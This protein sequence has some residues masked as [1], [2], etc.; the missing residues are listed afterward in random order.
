[1]GVSGL[2]DVS[3]S[4]L[5]T[6]SKLTH[7][8]VVRP[9]GKTRSLTEL[10]VTEGF[11]RNPD[12]VRGFRI[13][14]DAS[15][16]FFHAEYGKEGE[17]P[18]LRTLFF[19]CATLMK[20]PFLPLFVF[21]GPL[22]PEWKRG[23]KINRTGSKLIPGMKAIVESFG[24]EWRTAPG[25]A[26]A[27]L[28]YLNRIGV[29]DGILSD[30]VDNFLFGATTVI[31]NPSN[32]LSGN[33]ANP[34]LN[35]AGKDDKNHTKVYRIEDITSHPD[36][37]LTRGGMILIGLLSGGDY[38]QGGLNRC[39]TVTAHGL[40]KCGFGDTLFQA[41]NNMDRQQ[42]EIFLVAWRHE[43]CH[44][45]RTN[46]QGHIG[47]KQAAL[48]NSVPTDFPNI[49]ILL[50]YTNPITSESK[51]R[52]DYYS[53][54]TWSKEPDLGR[55]AATCEFYFE[56]GYKE[57]II[58][59]FRT[60]IWHSAVLRILRRAVLDLDA[61]SKGAAPL[62]V[63]PRKA[64]KSTEEPIGTPSK[65]IAKHFSSMNLNDRSDTEDE[66]PLI[67][68]V[69][70]ERNHVSTDGIL[71]YRLE[72]APAQLVRI[73]ESGIKGTRQ[74]E[75]PDE[76]AED[77]EDED[78]GGRA[79]KGVKNPPPDPESHM[80]LWMPACMV[81]LVEP[82]LVEKFE[83]VLETKRVK[84]AGKGRGKTK[85]KATVS[86]EDDTALDESPK[87]KTT[88]A[89]KKKTAP[90]APLEDDDCALDISSKPRNQFKTKTPTIS[91]TTKEG[92]EEEEVPQSS[93]PRIRDLTKKKTTSSSTTG[94]KSFFPATKRLTNT[95][96]VK[97]SGSSVLSAL[98]NLSTSTAPFSMEGEDST[99]SSKTGRSVNKALDTASS[100]TFQPAK[101]PVIRDLTK[102][103]QRITVASAS[104][105]ING[106]DN[107]SDENGEYTRMLASP[108]RPNPLTSRSHAPSAYLAVSDSD[109]DTTAAK[110]RPRLGYDDSHLYD[111]DDPFTHSSHTPP[112]KAKQS[113]K[114]PLS[115]L[116]SD[117]EGSIGSPSSRIYKSPRK[118]QKHTS[119]GKK[120]KPVKNERPC[121]PTP[122]KVKPK[123][124]VLPVIEIS[125]SDDD[126]DDELPPMHKV[127]QLPPLMRAKARVDAKTS[128][129]LKQA[130]L[131]TF[132]NRT[133]KPKDV[134]RDVIDLT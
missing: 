133:E 25:E 86:D 134:N 127:A 39:G 91:L 90:G 46:S 92:L 35:A 5:K 132:V 101:A 109:E 93:A 30:D 115:V 3:T 31:R 124:G 87:P 44:E 116:S 20:S 1:M 73:A 41:A 98:D 51:G 6:T 18:V 36:I 32:N 59:R 68:K 100:S 56:W 11:E 82:R 64:G 27:E 42:L 85:A 79:A 113:R 88:K 34:V 105:L 110:T 17:N 126:S 71:E 106:E 75:G 50:S 19:R 13:G 2:W 78:G 43:L 10:S 111:S 40:A 9:T 15:I 7:E 103:G 104:K 60:V 23:K 128:S 97:T 117:S 81:R 37:L 131:S 130:S 118:S 94:I 120:Q 33:R 47:R 70:S 12:G 55:L 95:A 48:A 24:F 122:A 45:L 38:N 52:A 53:N 125:D 28:A 67:V 16:W 21:D 83:N 129:T 29:I 72:I 57:A 76:W 102:R 99:L 96:N 74:P 123:T 121:S 112:P 108:K 77:D 84:K 114:Q 61:K 66:E 63:T 8:Q 119:P 62:P 4:S 26:E 14:I 69:H 22:R 49:D 54:L 58:K 80:R 107:C 65:M 89:R